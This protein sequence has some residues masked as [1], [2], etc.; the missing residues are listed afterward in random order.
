M[1]ELLCFPLPFNGKDKSRKDLATFLLLEYA[2]SLIK[3]ETTKAKRYL[4][5]VEELLC[6]P[7]PFN[8]KEQSRQD[9]DH[10]I[11]LQ[12]HHYSWVLSIRIMGVF[13]D[14]YAAF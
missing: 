6:F 9:L 2:A 12:I 8:R 5:L 7:V 4:Q 10:V 13:L 1:R 3:K 11:S 14:S